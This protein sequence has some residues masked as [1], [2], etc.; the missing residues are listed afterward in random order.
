MKFKLYFPSGFKNL[1]VFNGNV[2][3]NIITEDYSVYFVVFYTIEHIKSI[4]ERES[5]VWYWDEDMVVINNLEMETIKVAIADLISDG[6]L[7]EAAS[8]LGDVNSVYSGTEYFSALND[9][10]E[11]AQE[12]FSGA[13]E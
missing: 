1:D 8:K 9:W 2:D 12:I 13:W 3:V 11:N 5:K 6:Y 4:M 10:E 7:K